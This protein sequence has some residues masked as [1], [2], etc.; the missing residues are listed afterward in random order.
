[1]SDY[2]IEEITIKMLD[3]YV[4]ETRHTHMVPLTRL[5]ALIYMTTDAQLP[6]L[7]AARLKQ[8]IAAQ[9]GAAI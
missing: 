8:I 1:M 7:I 9:Q 2:L 6:S 4:A 5:E 3:V